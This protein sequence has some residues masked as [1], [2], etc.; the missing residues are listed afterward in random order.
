[1][2]SS[3][4]PRLFVL[5]RIPDELTSA[6]SDEFTLVDRA[7]AGSSVHP[8]FE[9]AVTTSMLGADAA[10]MA[11]LP[12]LR[13]IA[14]NGVGLE[15]IDLA[16]ARCRNIEV[17]NTPDAVT[18][19][20]AEYAI[21]LIYATRRNLFGADNFVRVGRWSVERPKPTSR[22]AR[23]RLGILGMGRIGKAIAERAAM[24]GL[25]ISYTARSQKPA[26]PFR[27]VPDVGE[28]AEQSDVLVVAC[29]GGE[30]TK[31]LVD[32]VVL[33]R[34]GPEGTLIN[35]ARGSVV[36]EPALIAALIERRIAA[37]AIDVFEQ[38][39]CDYRKFAGLENII[40]SPHVAA[41]THET[42]ADIAQTLL[43]RIRRYFQ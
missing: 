31:G 12:D 20:T 33:S 16:E 13:L 29:P 42:R 24:L 27:F 41:I 37:A 36:Q 26:L 30:E 28:L 23:C 11:S 2:R 15:N 34:L 6:L 7:R 8:G 43:E 5:G 4:R 9:V 10:V 25:Q 14:C 3:E 17:C 40:L 39:P 19:D 22:V 18:L 1:M 32:E 21:A 38:E 35:I